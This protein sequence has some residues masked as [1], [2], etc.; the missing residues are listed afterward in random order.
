MCNRHLPVNILF[1]PTE[2]EFNVQN[3]FKM[4]DDANIME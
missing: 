1:H 3:G 4:V 2:L